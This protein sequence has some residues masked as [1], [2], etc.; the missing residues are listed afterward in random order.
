MSAAYVRDDIRNGSVAAGGTQDNGTWVVDGLGNTV[1]S[2]VKR[3]WSRRY[4]I[5]N[6][7]K[8]YLDTYL[9]IRFRLVSYLKFAS[10]DNDFTQKYDQT[11][12]NDR[13]AAYCKILVSLIPH[14]LY[15]NQPKPIQN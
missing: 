7:L 4:P 2:G 13:V 15:G 14:S 1:M 9:Y 5:L 3:R 12:Y 6:F 11:F 10:R 8:N